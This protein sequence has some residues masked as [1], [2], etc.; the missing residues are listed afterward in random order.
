MCAMVVR[1]FEKIGSHMDDSAKPLTI[2]LAGFGVVGSGLCQ[3]LRENEDIVLRRAG[4][5][6]F[7]K[8]ILVRNLDKARR[9]APPLGA[10]MTSDL[11]DLTD[12]SEIDA[13]AELIGGTETARELIERALDKGKHV[14]TAN[15]ALLAKDGMELFKRACQVNKILRYE[16][17]VAGAIPVVAALKESLNGNRISGLTGILNGTSNY[18]LSEMTNAGLEFESALRRAQELGYAEAD[19]SLDIDGDDAAHKLIVLIR[20]AYGVDYPI[21]KLLTQG[22]RGIS[23][24]DVRLAGE[25]GYNIKLI[26]EVRYFRGSDGELRLG[27]GVFPALASRSML[28]ANVSGAYNAIGVNANAAGPLFFHGKGAGS[29]PTAGAVLAD[30]VAVARGEYPN[31]SG[32]ADMNWPAVKILPPA[33]WPS[34]YYLRVMVDDTSGVL[35]DISGCLAAENISVA[36]MIQKAQAGEACVPLVFMTH[37]TTSQAMEKALE[38]AE[39]AKLLRGKP[40]A[41]RVLED[42]K[43]SW[44][45]QPGD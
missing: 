24:M 36:Q 41:Y 44:N 21:D 10:Q 4:K 39:K 38:R 20:L 17:S 35:R 43:A 2:G 15:K 26:G 30:L 5:R 27:A 13:I 40:V 22:I 32:F 45:I 31:N 19:P 14:I 9:I 1:Y 23:A 12:D 3:L 8:K 6:I 11:K 28:L 42:G 34:C 25:F 33:E 16:A 37:E 18:I 7:V 29:L